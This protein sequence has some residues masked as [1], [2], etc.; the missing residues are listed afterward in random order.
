[1]NTFTETTNSIITRIKEE[2]ATIRANR[3]TPALVEDIEVEYYGAK[4]PL[5]QA[6][7]I[8]MKPPREI[9]IQAWDQAGAVAI[10]KGI[11]ESHKKSSLGSA[12]AEGL[13]V[14]VFLPELSVE[15][16]QELSKLVK[17]TVE[18]YRI[19]I[20]TARED[21]NKEIDIAAK[22][23]ELTE[24]D[25]FQEKEKIQKETEKANKQIE[26][27]LDRKLAEINE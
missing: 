21:A 17:K 8:S 12:S 13:V 3:L 4:M 25:K 14:R 1:M 22:R 2:L 23:G 11:E 26:E 9:Q 5:K 15:R 6:G 20:R 19:H 18:S 7:S 27:I 10:I 24:D 16:R